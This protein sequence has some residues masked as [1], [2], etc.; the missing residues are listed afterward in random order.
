MSS[1]TNWPDSAKTQ[2]TTSTDIDFL[3]RDGVHFRRG[4]KKDSYNAFALFEETWAGV[5]RRRGQGENTSFA[6]PAELS[7]MWA[8]RRH[9]YEYLTN[10]ADQFGL[11]EHHGR[12]IGFARAI[13]RGS[14]RILTEFFV[15]PG[16]QANGIGRALLARALP[17]DSVPNQAI[18]AT[19]EPAAQSLYLRLGVSPRFPVYYFGRAS[20]PVSLDTDLNILPL[21]LTP[22]L[23]SQLAV[24]DKE[25]LG[26]R[27]DQDH[28]WMATHQTGFV[29]YRGE[30]LV[31]YG[32]TGSVNGPFLAL[33]PTDFPAILGHA[34]NVAF[35]QGQTHF[36]LEIPTVNRD[37]LTYLID[38]KFQMDPIVTVMMNSYP[39]GDFSRYIIISPPFLM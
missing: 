5:V 4:T 2:F 31:A 33:N 13:V 34:E 16:Q 37:A 29:C 15:L 10:I 21:Q 24:L 12:P 14:I 19:V 30:Q 32:Y 22:D 9:L 20:R 39:F 7:E 28:R 8:T 3:T 18:L 35:R 27:R 6:N 17:K 38:Q 36:G 23:L 26:W 11:A 25:I 1:L